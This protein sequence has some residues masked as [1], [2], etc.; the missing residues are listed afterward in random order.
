MGQLDGDAFADR[1]GHRRRL[2]SRPAIDHLCRYERYSS[3]FGADGPDDGNRRHA[4]QA[5]ADRAIAL[6]R[7]AHA[8]AISDATTDENVR[9]RAGLVITPSPLDSGLSGYFQVTAITGGTLYTSDGAAP[10]ADGQFITFAEGTAGLRFTPSRDS[11]AGGSFV[12]QA[13]TAA[14]AG[15]LDGETVTATITVTPLPLR[16]KSAGSTV[17]GSSVLAIDG[18][19]LRV[20]RWTASPSR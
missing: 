16:I 20:Q 6:V 3:G 8:P 19:A 13:A 12:V 5:P 2:S 9:S 18:T 11:V 17:D 10:I 15:T 7:I 4:E 1:H 14:D